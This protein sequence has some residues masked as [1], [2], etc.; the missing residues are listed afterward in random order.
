MNAFNGSLDKAFQGILR[1][2]VKLSGYDGVFLCTCYG[3]SPL[4]TSW[5]IEGHNEFI[6]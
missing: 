5:N 6:L 1:D 4:W 3:V 2:C